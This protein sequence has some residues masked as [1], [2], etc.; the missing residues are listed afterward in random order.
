MRTQSLF[1]P[2]RST[3]KP[4]SARAVDWHMGQVQLNDVHALQA[5]GLAFA[6]ITADGSVITWGN[7]EYG[8]HSTQV[9]S[10]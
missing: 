8:A 6:A 9:G 10:G 3:R 4:A 5:T 1:A 7:A 2:T